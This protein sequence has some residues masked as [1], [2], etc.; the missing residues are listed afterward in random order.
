[1]SSYSTDSTLT[2]SHPMSRRTLAISIAVVFPGS[3]YANS[4]VSGAATGS[5]PLGQPTRTS[6]LT[7]YAAPSAAVCLFDTH[8]AS[9]N[10]GACGGTGRI[11]CSSATRSVMLKSLGVKNG[12]DDGAWKPCDCAIRSRKPT[13]IRRYGFEEIRSSRVCVSNSVT[14]NRSAATAPTVARTDARA[15]TEATAPQ[16]RYLPPVCRP[17]DHQTTPTNST[18]AKATTPAKTKNVSRN[19]AR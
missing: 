19:C 9:P 8:N 16:S 1:M 10:D 6:T 14:A 4:T 2:A 17:P 18:L 12:H 5:S 3:T 7:E 13:S 15:A 11:G